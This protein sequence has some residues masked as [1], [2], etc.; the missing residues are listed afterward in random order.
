MQLYLSPL[1]AGNENV[2]AARMRI[3]HFRTNGEQITLRERT[4][5]FGQVYIYDHLCSMVTQEDMF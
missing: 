3:V 1:F 2:S 4:H 5:L